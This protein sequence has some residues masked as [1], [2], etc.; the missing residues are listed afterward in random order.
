MRTHWAQRKLNLSYRSTFISFKSDWWNEKYYG[1]KNFLLEPGFMD[2]RIKWWK[3]KWHHSLLTL[4]TQCE[5]IAFCHHDLMLCWPR[6]LSSKRKKN[7]NTRRHNT[8]LEFKTGTQ[9]HW[10]LHASRETRR[11]KRKKG[12]PVFVWDGWFWL[13]RKKLNFFTTRV[14]QSVSAIKKDP[15]GCLLV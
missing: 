6:S 1:G 12:I 3:W 14:R 10:S 7:V 9:S 8:E 4:V 13:T 11:N 2:P 15:L 5:I